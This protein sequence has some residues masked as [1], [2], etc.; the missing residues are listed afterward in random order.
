MNPRVRSFGR[1]HWTRFPSPCLDAPSAR[2][3]HGVVFCEHG[4]S[5]H[6]P[7]GISASEVESGIPAVLLESR[8]AAEVVDVPRPMLTRK[9]R[10]DADEAGHRCTS[11]EHHLDEDR[12]VPPVT[13][14]I[15]EGGFA[16]VGPWVHE[17]GVRRTI[18]R[19]MKCWPVHTTNWGWCRPRRQ[20]GGKRRGGRNRCRSHSRRYDRRRGDGPANTFCECPRRQTHLG[21][22]PPLGTRALHRRARSAHG[23]RRITH[24]GPACR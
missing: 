21:P 10:V 12:L 7:I 1:R 3:A 4:T 6:E 2:T 23:W 15:S 19:R 17:V 16:V 14:E 20:C 18:L 8:V 9:H 22:S 11:A 24:P 5:Q 13:R